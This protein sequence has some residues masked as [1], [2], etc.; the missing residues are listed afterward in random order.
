MAFNG[1]NL[2]RRK[3]S[4]VQP[5]RPRSGKSH[6]LTYTHPAI[7]KQTKRSNADK[8]TSQSLQQGG[9]KT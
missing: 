5:V 4:V 9:L 8:D 3:L 2:L 7:G 1:L 6:R